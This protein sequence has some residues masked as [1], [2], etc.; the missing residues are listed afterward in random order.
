MS[1]IHAVTHRPLSDFVDFLWLSQGYVQPHAAERVLP[2]GRMDLVIGLDEATAIRALAAGAR[3]TS[4]LLGTS[5]PLTLIGVRFKPGG[6]FPFFA[7]AAGELQD[8]S[9]PLDALWGPTA[10]SL[11]EQLLE[12][13]I[14]RRQF[15]ILERHLLER[16]RNG[17]R[18]H[19]AVQYALTTFQHTAAATV[20]T[21]VART[22]LSARKLI[23]LFRG[24]VGLTPKVFARMCRFRRVI[25]S[26][27]TRMDVDWAETALSC[28]YFD[29]PHFIH[30]FRAFAGVSPAVYLRHRTA[31][32]NH[33]RIAD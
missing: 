27:D 1:L 14:P 21:V 33:V 12:A 25:G 9:V 11:R 31:N 5:T 29:Q 2:T 30:D 16:L 3:S 17:P 23:E 7:C 19:P 6:G 24:Q 32:P 18:R 15:A 22:G 4:F 26:L 8:L 28:G 20:A 10:N 13:T